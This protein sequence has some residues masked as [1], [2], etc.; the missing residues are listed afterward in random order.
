VQ[1]RWDPTARDPND[2]PYADPTFGPGFPTPVGVRTA[3]VADGLSNTLLVSE[4]RIDRSQLGQP[5]TNDNNGYATGL[6]NDTCALH[7]PPPRRDLPADPTAHTG[8]DFGSS[9][10][11]G[12]NAV[13]ADGSVRL[14]RYSITPTTFVRLCEVSDGQVLGNDW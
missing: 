5:Q 7:T 9:H 14:V 8:N 13:L 12:M 1:G 11:D 6:D 4:K 2:L 10:A 3:T